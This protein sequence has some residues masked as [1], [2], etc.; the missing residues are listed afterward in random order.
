MRG[1]NI[2]ISLALVSAAILT[3]I[4]LAYSVKR[5]TGRIPIPPAETYEPSPSVNAVSSSP[6]VSAS[7]SPTPTPVVSSVVSSA[8]P[9]TKTL[10]P[11]EM[12]LA[13]PFTVQAP[14]RNW[15]LPYEEFCEE[16]SVLMA[17][18]FVQ[19]RDIPD[20]NLAD[21]A[22]LAI[23]AFEDK[24]F[25]YYEDTTADE[26]TRI[27]R[28]YFG[29]NQV[30]L[31][32]DPTIL[33]IKTALA[34]RKAVIMPVAGREIGNPYFQQP[35]PLYHMLVIKGYTSNGEFITNDPGT[36][37]GADYMYAENVLMRAMHDWNGGD[38]LHG[39]KVIIIV[40]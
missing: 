21:Q 10:L 6:T 7:T 8:S 4:F 32:I 19:K 13:V 26:T 15:S 33:D 23:K 25:G 28:E 20:A 1:K 17:A 29:I 3:G 37:R 18:S 16:S 31:A 34:N 36:R 2:T 22:L 9:S 24:T 11:V 38:V 35:G 39:R 5:Q 40:G 12:N 14:L 27:L 30:V